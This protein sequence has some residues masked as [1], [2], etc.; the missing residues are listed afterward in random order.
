MN[1]AKEGKTSEAQELIKDFD[2]GSLKK[3]K[4]DVK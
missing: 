1:L 3:Q 4:E 2:Y